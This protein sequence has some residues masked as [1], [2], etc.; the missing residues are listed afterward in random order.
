MQHSSVNGV[1]AR[2][3][4]DKGIETPDEFLL[5]YLTE[6]LADGDNVDLEQIS[7]I[8]SSFS[9]ALAGEAA[10]A[11]ALSLVEQVEFV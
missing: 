4:Q 7:D 10:T 6:T 5:T 11:A 1:V 9:T 3:F 8:L 2:W